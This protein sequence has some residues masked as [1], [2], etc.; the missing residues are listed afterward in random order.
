[1]GRHLRHPA[2]GVEDGRVLRWEHNGDSGDVQ[3]RCGAVHGYVPPQGVLALVHGRGNGRDGVHRGGEQHER[4]G[5]RVPAVPGRDGWKRVSSTRR[6][7]STTW[8][9]RRL[10]MRFD[11]VVTGSLR[12][13]SSAA[14]ELKHARGR[15]PANL[16]SSRSWWGGRPYLSCDST[17][18]IDRGHYCFSE[19]FK[20]LQIF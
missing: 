6:K 7:V 20:F 14:A 13:S 5:V 3:A 2:E 9:R 15:H 1:M 4:L 12:D 17:C 19:T 10:N 18:A 11:T 16:A 8:S